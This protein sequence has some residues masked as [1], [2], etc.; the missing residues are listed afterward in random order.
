MFKFLFC[1]QWSQVE[2]VH[3][4]QA[5]ES[6]PQSRFDCKTTVILK[7]FAQDAP[8]KRKQAGNTLR[9]VTEHILFDKF[10]LLKINVFF[11]KKLAEK[12]VYLDLFDLVD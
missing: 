10:V 11:K 3:E 4:L 5:N 2:I 7:K 9:L 6:L 8:K 1:F 12:L